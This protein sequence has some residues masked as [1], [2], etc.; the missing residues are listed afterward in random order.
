MASYDIPQSTSF[1]IQSI[2][3]TTNYGEVDV[4][5]MFMEI[6]LF[7]GVLQPCMSG[8][9]I[10][11]DAVGLANK[12]AFD[13]SEF[14]TI[15]MSK[16][17][18]FL[19]FVKTFHIYKLSDRRAVNLSMEAYILHFASEEF[20][21]SEQQ[22]VQQ[23]YFEKHSDVVGNILSDYLSVPDSK[24]FIEES[25]G[26]RKSVLPKMKPLDAITWCAKRALDENYRPNFLFFE[27]LQGFFFVS[28]SSIMKNDAIATIKHSISNLGQES[29]SNDYLS[30]K[31]IEVVSQ[32][33]YIDNTREGLYAGTFIGFDPLTRT[34][35]KVRMD[36]NSNLGNSE[37]ANEFKNKSNYRNPGAVINTKMYD[38]KITVFPFMNER[39]KSPWLLAND[40]IPT[41]TEDAP[42]KWMFQ[43]NAILKNM[44]S[45]IV[46][47]ALS[48]NFG[49]TSGQNI[50]MLVPV[51]GEK[52]EN[53]PN[54]NLDMSLSGRYLIIAARHVI[55]Y[56]KHETIL[57]LATDSTNQQ[58]T[59]PET[60]V[61]DSNGSYTT[62]NDYNEDAI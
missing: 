19:P 20:V 44:T 8:N 55:R 58:S 35:R 61:N 32:Y 12:L 26:I 10:I 21:Y 60:N 31:K 25:K 43:R 39:G 62:A 37:I 2:K 3:I 34:Y 6:N 18:D 22:R 17:A 23:N 15:S 59:A 9:I 51:R 33:D 14:I 57:E 7:D 54:D 53:D 42:E 4:R 11:Q 48:G 1:E 29:M 50:N 45:K 27:N 47:I 30:A 5:A 38:S 24:I 52:A 46:R 41:L 40:P 16:S 13:G 28:L 36:L 56:D 49:L